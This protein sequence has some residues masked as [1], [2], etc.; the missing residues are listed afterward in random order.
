MFG[1]KKKNVSLLIQELFMRSVAI[2]SSHL[3]HVSAQSGAWCGRA[4]AGIQRRW[5]AKKDS[6]KM[7]VML[8]LEL[9]C[10]KQNKGTFVL[11]I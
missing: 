8:T 6:P 9:E 10:E 1:K 2:T 4:P 3:L 5:I 7:F 11:I